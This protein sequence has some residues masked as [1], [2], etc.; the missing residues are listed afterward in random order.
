MRDKCKATE[1]STG[2]ARSRKPSVLVTSLKRPPQE[3]PCV[4]EFPWGE[5]LEDI[6]PGT[7]WARSVDTGFT[8]EEELGH[9][10]YAKQLP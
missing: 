8:P 1:P 7:Y 4:G 10:G 2:A 3:E 9:T 6:Q 5:K